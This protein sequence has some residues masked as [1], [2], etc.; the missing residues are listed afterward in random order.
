MR[1]ILA[2]LL[3]VWLLIASGPSHALE[4]NTGGFER[5]FGGARWIV[6]GCSSGYHMALE[7][8]DV[9]V[10]SG[11]FIVV[12]EHLQTAEVIPHGQKRAELAAAAEELRRM[13]FKDMLALLEQANR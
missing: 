13:P 9:E 2:M 1:F 11:I 3:G 8:Q 10:S 4:C 5:T 6:I 7:M 12:E